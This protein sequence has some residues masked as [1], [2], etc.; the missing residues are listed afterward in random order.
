MGEWGGSFQLRCPSRPSSQQL[1]GVWCS[2]CFL[3]SI[4]SFSSANIPTPYFSV[5]IWSLADDTIPKQKSWARVCPVS[6]RSWS[7]PT[8]CSGLSVAPLSK[9]QVQFLVCSP[10]GLKICRGSTLTASLVAVVT[11]F[12]QDSDYC[13]A[14]NWLGVFCSQCAAARSSGV[15]VGD[16]PPNIAWCSLG[17]WSR[18]LH[19]ANPSEV[20]KLS[21]RGLRPVTEWQRFIF[22]MAWSVFPT[23]LLN[24]WQL[25]FACVTLWVWIFFC[26]FH[27]W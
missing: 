27:S 25:L 15:L 26:L 12:W 17:K 19:T 11:L 24:T 9:P 5:I 18:A 2:H 14:F 22:V 4:R 8:S 16:F 3:Q 20:H 7:L 6:G 1:S 13:W 23:V 21:L 10:Q